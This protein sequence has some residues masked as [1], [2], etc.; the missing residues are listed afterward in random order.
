MCLSGSVG[1]AAEAGHDC[2]VCAAA[3]LTGAV[4]VRG[5]RTTTGTVLELVATGGGRRKRRS[6]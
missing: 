1:P 2:G 5:V 4:Q 6:H 3:R